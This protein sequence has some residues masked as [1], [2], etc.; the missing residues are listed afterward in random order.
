MALLQMLERTSQKGWKSNKT[1][2][3]VGHASKQVLQQVIKTKFNY[4][5]TL[6]SMKAA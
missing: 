5:L 1:N 4:F 6:C 2:T 3:E